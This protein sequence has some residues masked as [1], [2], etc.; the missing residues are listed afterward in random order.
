MS[1]RAPIDAHSQQMVSFKELKATSAHTPF[2]RMEMVSGSGI[3]VG[4]EII[5]P[6]FYCY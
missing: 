4:T 6:L 1:R 3:A 2:E 5:T